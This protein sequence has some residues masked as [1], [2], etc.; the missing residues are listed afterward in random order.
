MNIIVL[1][2][3]VDAYEICGEFGK[4]DG[5]GTNQF[6]AFEGGIM[7]ASKGRR[8]QQIQICPHAGEKAKA[9]KMEADIREFIGSLL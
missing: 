7:R 1:P 8:S 3:W 9:D 5:Y 2:W 4:P 6:H